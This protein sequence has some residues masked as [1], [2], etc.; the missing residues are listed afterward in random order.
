[1]VVATAILVPVMSSP[2]NA[3][4][5]T[6][7]C[8]PGE[9]I[10]LVG[11]GTGDVNLTTVKDC[12]A[13]GKWETTATYVSEKEVIFE[14]R[15]I[16]ISFS[17]DSAL[18]PFTRDYSYSKAKDLFPDPTAVE[19][20][21]LKQFALDSLSTK[22]QTV[23]S[24]K[25]IP[26][27]DSCTAFTKR[28]SDEEIKRWPGLYKLP[29]LPT[30]DGKT[31]TITFAFASDLTAE[32]RTTVLDAL[33]QYHQAQEG[34]K[35]P[36]IELASP[37]ST[38]K[39]TITFRDGAER[40]EGTTTAGEAVNVVS[41]TGRD[42]LSRWKSGDIYLTQNLEVLSETVVAHEILHVLS[43][44]HTPEHLNGVGFS[45]TTMAPELIGVVGTQRA[46]NSRSG[47][48]GDSDTIPPVDAAIDPCT[49]KGMS[50]ATANY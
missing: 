2:A 21:T 18:N 17:S 4:N 10:M 16:Q 34:T 11:G 13:E 22:A 29:P 44:Q 24:R 5:E 20:Q 14:K 30:P 38:E 42:D 43:F 27:T 3:Y 40:F 35:L 47:W 28:S 41:D 15:G 12:N 39:P 36:R 9:R 6:D 46:G 45:D 23:N 19:W 33:T 49:R 26:D 32:Q 1:V 31:G 8:I 37:T 25:T 7:I 50:M 48:G